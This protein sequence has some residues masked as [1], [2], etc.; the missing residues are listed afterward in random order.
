MLIDD[1]S[2]L[3]LLPL[4][5]RYGPSYFNVLGSLRDWDIV[6]MLHKIHCPTLLIS[7]PDDEVQELAVLP[8]FLEIPKIK[9]VELQSSTHLPMFEEPERYFLSPA[10]SIHFAES[11]PFHHFF[12]P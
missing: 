12:V 6:G 10:L 4:K 1:H 11:L 5:I 9:W 8:F 3:F 7:A 2:P